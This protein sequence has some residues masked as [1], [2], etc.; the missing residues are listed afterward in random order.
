MILRFCSI[1]MLLAVA[2]LRAQQCPTF[3][4]SERPQIEKFATQWFKLPPNQSLTLTESDSVDA[5]CYR[6]LIF[7]P[8]VPAPLLILYLTP[9]KQHLVTN[10]LDLRVD[11]AVTR[12][13]RQNELLNL[14]R[15]GALL[16]A[17]QDTAPAKLVVFSDFE[18]PYCKQFAEITVNGVTTPS[19]MSGG[20]MIH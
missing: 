4:V 9:D 19:A 18:C 17:G 1:S 16:T 14:L 20:T 6:K 13:E 10:V 2:A 12:R 15:S 11:P 3:T 5:G 7:R 8:S